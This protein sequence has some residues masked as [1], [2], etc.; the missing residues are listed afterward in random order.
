MWKDDELSCKDMSFFMRSMALLNNYDG[1]PVWH[2]TDECGFMGI[3]KDPSKVH[4][5]LT[6]IRY[7]DDYT[8]GKNI[9]EVYQRSCKDLLSCGEIT[10]EFYEEIKDIQPLETW[11]FRRSNENQEEKVFLSEYRLYVICFCQEGDS[12]CMWEKYAGNPGYALQFI[13]GSMCFQ[14]KCDIAISKVYY[15]EEEKVKK[16]KE[17]IL[18]AFDVFQKHQKENDCVRTIQG[19]LQYFLTVNRALFKNEKFASEQ[20]YRV[21]VKLP[22]PNEGGEVKIKYRERSGSNDMIPYIELSADSSCLTGVKI[23]PA[24]I[25]PEEKKEAV[26]RLLSERKISAEVSRSTISVQF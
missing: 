25:D 5:R 23:C 19:T 24:I 26:S 15:R 22:N 18:Q 17:Y 11:F 7:L 20:E 10:K 2:Y 21:I 4:I 6:D 12:L 3:L 1:C 8:E 16:V 13:L 14:E 9:T